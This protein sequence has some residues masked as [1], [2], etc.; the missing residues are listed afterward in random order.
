MLVAARCQD[1]ALNRSIY[2]KACFLAIC[3]FN[4]L[5][6]HALFSGFPTLVETHAAILKIHKLNSIKELTF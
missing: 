3:P 4:D 6:Q 1:I 5:Q 2:I